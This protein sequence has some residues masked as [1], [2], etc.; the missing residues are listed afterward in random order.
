MP[1]Y[2]STLSAELM[3]IIISRHFRFS[4]VR[5]SSRSNTLM[6]IEQFNEMTRIQGLTSLQMCRVFFDIGRPSKRL[7]QEVDLYKHMNL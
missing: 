2:E 5:Y 3:N 6:H 1:D 4:N 7:V